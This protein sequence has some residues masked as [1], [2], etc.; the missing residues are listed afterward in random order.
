MKNINNI[1]IVEFLTKRFA[2]EKSA[3]AF[4]VEKRWGG[5]IT[6]PYCSHD[7]IYQVTGSQPYKC[8]EC[9]RKFTAK[10][11]TI[12]EGSHISIRMWLLAMYLIGDS[13]KGISSLQM[14]KELGVT[15]KTAWF[16]AHRIRE[17]CIE[18]A[19][20]KGIVEMDETYIGGKE[21]NKHF[22]K[23]FNSGRG[24]ANKI[25]VVG[26]RERGGKAIGRVSNGTSAYELIDLIKKN[27]VPKTSV[28]TDDHPSYEGVEARGY[29]HRVVKHS[30]HE[31]VR[32]I[33]HT[34]GIESLWAL[35]KR[36]LYGTYHHVDRKHLA[37]YVNEFCFRLNR[38][39]TIP[40]IEAVC[41]RAN[42]NALRYKKL[43]NEH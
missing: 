23:R 20:L 4:F 39:G 7:K 16:M 25:P 6:C 9:R 19:K 28:F 31:Y 43:I 22:D 33:A 14:A 10:T 17:A 38:G 8:A 24:V 1:S 34:N 36:G 11:G 21:K 18:T 12:M 40:F 3:E 41:V 15:Q 27:I 2:D 13:R 37:R 5:K 29:K 30:K 26:M 42:G 35:L 32:G